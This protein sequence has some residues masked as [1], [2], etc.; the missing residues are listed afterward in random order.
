[1]STFVR[2]KVHPRQNLATPM[3][4]G[5]QNVSSGKKATIFVFFVRTKLFTRS[6]KNKR[7]V[8]LDFLARV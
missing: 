7:W 6:Q 4:W 5:P 2:K 3:I 8:L 1:M